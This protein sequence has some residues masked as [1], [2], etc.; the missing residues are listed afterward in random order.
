MIDNKFGNINKD[1]V[2]RPKECR[3]CKIKLDDSNRVRNSGY[4]GYAKICKKC[5]NEN[6]L[7]YSRK[8]SAIIK[9]NP[10]W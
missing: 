8:K 6:N 4:I 10:L 7:K 9:A 1:I 3:Q 2:I 5:R